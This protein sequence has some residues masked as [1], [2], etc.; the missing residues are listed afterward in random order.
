[1]QF[2]VVE[3][4]DKQIKMS[5]DGM[6]PMSMLINMTPI[7]NGERTEVSTSID[8]NLPTM[9]KPF[10]GPHLQKAADQFGVMMGKIAGGEGI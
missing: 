7:E 10:V 3:R 1:M 4:N 6:L 2:K 8:I 5:A 9:L